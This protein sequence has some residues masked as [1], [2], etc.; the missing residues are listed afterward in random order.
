[1]PAALAA[2]TIDIAI[3]VAP[4]SRPSSRKPIRSEPLVALLPAG[5]PLAGEPALALDSLADEEFVLFPR[6]MAPRLHDAF[7][8]TTGAPASNLAC[9]KSRSTPAGTS[10]SSTRS[11]P[12]RRSRPRSRRR[13][14]TTARRSR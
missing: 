7:M 4:R 9:A 2:G 8:A 14:R 11:A 10:G 12:P 13:C 3:A 1:M 5:H 6:E